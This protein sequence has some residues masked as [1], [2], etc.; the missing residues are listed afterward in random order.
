MT[1]DDLFE[2]FVKHLV[3]IKLL[4]L[5]SPDALYFLTMHGTTTRLS[6]E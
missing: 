5:S 4:A 3:N 1:I 6:L 2:R